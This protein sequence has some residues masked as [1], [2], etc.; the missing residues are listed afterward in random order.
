MHF[1]VFGK[2]QGQPAQLKYRRLCGLCAGQSA[3][4]SPLP[5]QGWN[6]FDRTDIEFRP[7]LIV[8]NGGI[9][10]CKLKTGGFIAPWGD[11]FFFGTHSEYDR[12]DAETV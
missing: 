1:D 8:E 5:L 4:P 9:P 6:D 11:F 10:V 12:I 3:V 2:G 7:R